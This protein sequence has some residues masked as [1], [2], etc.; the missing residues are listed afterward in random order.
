MTTICQTD[1]HHNH[2]RRVI[3]W[4]LAPWLSC[5]TRRLIAIDAPLSTCTGGHSGKIAEK[6][7]VTSGRPLLPS[8]FRRLAALQPATR[9]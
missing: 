5:A 7:G 8:C 9:S 2:R 6:M 4:D 3:C 1:R